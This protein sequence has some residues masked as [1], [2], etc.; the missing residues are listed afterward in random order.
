MTRFETLGVHSSTPE[1]RNRA[2]GPEREAPRGRGRSRGGRRA[3][4]WDRPRSRAAQGAAGRRRCPF[5]ERVRGKAQVP[6]LRG[7]TF[8]ELRVNRKPAGPTTA[9]QS[10][11]DGTLEAMEG[12]QK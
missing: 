8:A 1:K 12:K 7:A 2:R 10:C 9:D 4:V 6:A 11:G 5:A 3:C